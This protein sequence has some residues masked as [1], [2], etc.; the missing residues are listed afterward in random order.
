MMLNIMI[1]VLKGSSKI[2]NKK[3]VVVVSRFNEFIT[4]KL[5]DGCLREL[6]RLGMKQSDITVAWVPGSFEIPV[7]ALKFSQKKKIAAVICLGSIIRGETIHFDLVAGAAARGI[8]QVS[9]TTGKPVIFGVLATDTVEQ[10]YKRS[11]QDKE[12]K[13][14]EAARNTL[15]MMSLIEQI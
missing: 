9:L 3:I 11:G 1:K 2:K 14:I 5:L 12:N 4:Q 8:A 6:L 15:E 13:G 7:V 10:A